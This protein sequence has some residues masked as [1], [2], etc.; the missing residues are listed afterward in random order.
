MNNL[1]KE[2]QASKT[3]IKELFILSGLT[4]TDQDGYKNSW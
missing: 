2:K 4:M 3:Y 1:I